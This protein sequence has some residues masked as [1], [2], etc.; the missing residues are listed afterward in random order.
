MNKLKTPEINPLKAHKSLGVALSHSSSLGTPIG[1]KPVQKSLKERHELAKLDSKNPTKGVESIGVPGAETA[2]YEAEKAARSTDIKK[3]DKFVPDKEWTKK[4]DSVISRLDSRVG[5]IESDSVSPTDQDNLF[6]IKSADPVKTDKLSIDY[7][8]TDKL[9]IKGWS[10]VDD[11]NI[12]T[13]DA[14]TV[15]PSKTTAAA[16]RSMS[17]LMTYASEY[18]KPQSHLYRSFV[19]DVQFDTSTY[20]LQKKIEWCYVVDPKGE[21]AWTMI[22]G[23]QAGYCTG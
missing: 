22:T 15:R 20:Q 13:T 10:T 11:S 7:I 4:I 1:Q 6:E 19:T 12:L 5:L 14:F 9:E 2:K 17:S 23:G 16:F 21:S 8:P 18:F 3:E